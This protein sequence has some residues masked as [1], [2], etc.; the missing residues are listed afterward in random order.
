MRTANFDTSIN[1]LAHR[2]QRLDRKLKLAKQR[3]ERD[4]LTKLNRALG[5]QRLYVD[6]DGCERLI[7]WNERKSDRPK[8]AARTRAGGSCKASVVRGKAR[9]RLHGGCSTGPR[10]PEG[11]ARSAAGVKAYWER[12][13]AA[14]EAAK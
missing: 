10:T 14:R 7:G 4:A 8:C 5:E 6:A 12:W 1:R 13:R 3:S 11:K 2:L 9:C